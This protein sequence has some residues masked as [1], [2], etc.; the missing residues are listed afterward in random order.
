MEGSRATG[1]CQT[2]DGPPA[3]VT[4]DL[5]LDS[6]AMTERHGRPL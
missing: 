1:S 5:L 3:M 2:P 4:E 6:A